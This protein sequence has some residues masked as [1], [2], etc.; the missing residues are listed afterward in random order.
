MA[1]GPHEDVFALALASVQERG[2]HAHPFPLATHAVLMA[3]VVALGEEIGEFT[4]AMRRNDGDG[5]RVELADCMVAL[6]SIAHLCAFPVPA[7]GVRRGQA[8]APIV[9]A[10][11]ELCRSLRY[12][13][14]LPERVAG[15][16]EAIRRLADSIWTQAG[17]PRSAC[18]LPAM[19]RRKLAADAER[20]HLH[21][22]AA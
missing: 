21:G 19:M 12:A 2:W 1:H 22:G 10:Y 5:A 6:V 14:D 9:V 11:G 20:G 16:H 15:I 18:D 7:L 3:E 17:Q 13:R 8:Q 4:E